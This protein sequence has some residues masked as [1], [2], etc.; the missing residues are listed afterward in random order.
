[1][2]KERPAQSFLSS[3]IMYRQYT[4]ALVPLGNHATMLLRL[5]MAG[6]H[7]SMAW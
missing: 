7:N 6:S 5:F 3:L 4:A 2:T 1:L